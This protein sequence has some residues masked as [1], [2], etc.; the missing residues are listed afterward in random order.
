MTAYRATRAG[1]E[2]GV[3]IEAATVSAA[4]SL[5]SRTLEAGAFAGQ[6]IALT[7]LFVDQ[8]GIL[9][10]TDRVWKKPAA[11]KWRAYGDAIDAI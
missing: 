2:P 6:V 11:G 3:L 5:A 8:D 9:I 4:K 10:R 7:E 1:E